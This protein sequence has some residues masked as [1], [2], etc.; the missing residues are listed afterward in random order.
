[1]DVNIKFSDLSWSL[2]DNSNTV[3]RSG[4]FFQATK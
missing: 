3:D 1:M 4:D 2:I